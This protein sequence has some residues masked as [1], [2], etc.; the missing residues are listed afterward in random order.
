M[1]VLIAVD[2]HIDWLLTFDLL[3]FSILVLKDGEIIESG[4]HQALV[5]ANGTFAAMWAEQITTESEQHS[6]EIPSE[7]PKT[8]PAGY[9]ITPPSAIV[10]LPETQVEPELNPP[11]EAPGL[12]LAPGP[13]IV[14]D[15]FQN[16][17]VETH[18]E[19]AARTAELNAAPA[20]ES[21][22]APE[23]EAAP[24][25]FVDE[26]SLSEVAQTT[27]EAPVLEVAPAAEAP[28]YAA[29]ASQPPAE[30]SAAITF[31]TSVADEPVSQA[32]EPEVAD[33]T[34]EAPSY[35][36]VASQPPA[37]DSAAITFPSSAEPE[38]ETK[39]PAEPVAVAPIA[40]PTSSEP[41]P[42]SAPVAFPSDET[43]AAPVAFPSSSDEP[44]A[45]PIAFPSDN[46]STHESVPEP[47]GT[48]TPVGDTASLNAAGPATPGIKFAPTT[49]SPSSRPSTPDP[50]ASDKRKRTTSQ[51][52][53]RLA[54]RISLG[55][56]R[57]SI[58]AAEAVR[59]VEAA[60]GPRSDSPTPIENFVSKLTGRSSSFR[61]KDERGSLKDS[62]TGGSQ[63][64]A[65]SIKGPEDTGPASASG[66]AIISP[67]E[68]TTPPDTPGNGG[69]SKKIKKNKKK[70][71]K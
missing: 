45:A 40:F 62:I 48:K 20:E 35:A 39:A 37:E 27:Q 7:G 31:P 5:A 46:Q 15:L 64:G 6:I 69:G 57:G 8:F 23:V 58:Q 68:E 25:P 12:S 63:K 60:G 24:T 41:E 52:L 14:P 2:K 71:K 13:V 38:T 53:S 18:S 34:A 70:G 61:D 67:E 55:G 22:E 50:G 26:A 28:S 65:E 29:V 1:Y 33:A 10:H 21:A 47:T 19:L 49:G 32:V 11:A 3:S 66:S 4:N 56:R 16:L 9:A 51:N 36:A 30:N 59:A 54:R 42:T 17:K 44:K 43:P